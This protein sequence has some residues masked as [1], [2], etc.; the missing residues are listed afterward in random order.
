MVSHKPTPALLCLGEEVDF[1][2][3]DSLGFEAQVER[4]RAR[5]QPLVDAGDAAPGG[6][7]GLEWLASA[8]AETRKAEH[9]K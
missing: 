2:P 9:L 5:L 1:V 7:V 8:A 4:L 6:I 3:W